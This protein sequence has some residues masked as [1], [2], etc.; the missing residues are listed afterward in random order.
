MSFCVWQGGQKFFTVLSFRGARGGQCG[1]QSPTAQW[2][3]IACDVGVCRSP[4]L[5]NQVV[6]ARKQLADGLESSASLWCL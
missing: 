2:P 1:T 5:K 6:Q 3:H 4:D